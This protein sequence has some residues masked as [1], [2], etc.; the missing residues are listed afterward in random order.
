MWLISKY[1]NAL[2]GG[3]KIYILNNTKSTFLMFLYQNSL[4][5]KFSYQK[6]KE[7]NILKAKG[8]IYNFKSKHLI[9]V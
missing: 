4:K 7:K 9:L 5:K 2:I 6:D 1:A 3:A 8:Y